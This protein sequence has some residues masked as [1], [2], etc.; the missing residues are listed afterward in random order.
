MLYA[1]DTYISQ[2]T[3][4]TAMFLVCGITFP[5]EYLPNWL[6]LLGSIIP[7]TDALTLMRGALLGGLS[8]ES[9]MLVGLREF[10]LGTM[11]IVVGF[12]LMKQV[13]RIALE[14]MEG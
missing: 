7:V 12:P 9:F 6:Q 10:I 14:K 1:R 2:N 13:E 8:T 3:L 4:F 5:K 11:Y